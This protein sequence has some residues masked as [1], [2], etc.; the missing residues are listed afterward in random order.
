MKSSNGI[1]GPFVKTKL[2]SMIANGEVLPTTPIRRGLVGSF[3][4]SSQFLS[5]S[6]QPAV[7]TRRAKEVSTRP[8]PLIPPP[9]PAFAKTRPRSKGFFESLWVN[10]KQRFAAKEKRLKEKE[11]LK[12]ARKGAEKQLNLN[13]DYEEYLRLNKGHKRPMPHTLRLISV[14]VT[15]LPIP[16]WYGFWYDGFVEGWLGYDA[17][18]FPR[19][20]ERKGFCPSCGKVLRSRNRCHLCDWTK[21]YTSVLE[22]WWDLYFRGVV[23][24]IFRLDTLG[25]FIIVA[26]AI[27][28]LVIL[29]TIGSLAT[30]IKQ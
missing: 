6:E 15:C 29:W 7:N 13:S 21:R 14:V 17:K 16:F 27:Q 28:F 30:E 3:K 26:I 2:T 11:E 5:V 25:L 24:V 22:K 23:M 4:P 19:N 8:R 20:F 10:I 9:P 12:A 18:R 1:Q